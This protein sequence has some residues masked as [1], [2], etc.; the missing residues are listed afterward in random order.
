MKR[1]IEIAV[2]I[3]SVAAYGQD[4]SRGG[5]SIH[6][7]FAADAGGRTSGI[8]TNV[9]NGIG[10][11]RQTAVVLDGGV[12]TITNNITIP[13]NIELV[14][15][16]GSYLS[17]AAGSTVTVNTAYGN[18]LYAADVRASTN[19]YA[20]EFVEN[21]T[22][23]SNKYSAIGSAGLS[24][25]GFVLVGPLTGTTIYASAELIGASN[26]FFGATRGILG[27]I[28]NYSYANDSAVLA[29]MNNV[30]S[31]TYAAVLAGQGNVSR[32]TFSAVG[33]GYGS[34]ASGQGAFVAAGN[35]ASASAPYSFAHGEATTSS[36]TNS[37]SFGRSSMASGVDSFAANRQSTAGGLASAAFGFASVATNS[38]SF[39]A[40]RQVTAGGISSLA[41]GYMAE[42]RGHASIALGYEVIAHAE[43]SFAEGFQTEAYAA[44]S[45]AEGNNTD[46]NG[47]NSHAQNYGTLASGNNSHAGG[48]QS[49]SSGENSFTHGRETV[50]SG[51]QA[52]SAG[53]K[54][55]A[56]GSNSVAM[57]N[58][59]IAN[60]NNAF[61]WSD[62]T[63]TNNS[64][65]NS[66]S[67]TIAATEGFFV[68]GQKIVDSQ[69]NV[70]KVPTNAVQNR[71]YRI[72]IGQDCVSSGILSSVLGGYSNNVGPTLSFIGGGAFNFISGD[73]SYSTIIGGEGN[74]IGTSKAYSQA[75]GY[76]ARST[77][78]SAWVWS[79]F[80][81]GTPF[82]SATNNSFNVRASG[83]YYLT[84]GPISGN[85]SGLTNAPASLLQI[86]SG[87]YTGGSMV[88]RSTNGTQFFWSPN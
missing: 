29:G 78:I 76:Y 68:N 31:N 27:G 45:H 18:T 63:S 56:S 12:W 75:S 16:R 49:A 79:D 48:Y 60:Y 66:N 11:N 34:T 1:L 24:T 15:A 22:A 88:L 70:S 41:A 51:V 67:F 14:Y 30:V 19:V 87:S 7:V 13:S 46:A 84:G 33:S 40:G 53:H 26:A 47:A 62:G 43:G 4:L 2:L 21:G 77:N 71:D 73:A 52:F 65:S 74:Y 35:T 17:V 61:V 10:T 20:V 64:S 82:S 25:N 8:L 23:L 59:S 44:N 50:S 42:A 38:Y 36:G 57:G 9:L 69:G 83:G 3:A 85:A 80:Q 5:R 6:Q 28:A 81:V 86:N 58:L 37:A 54:T 39:A 72:V 32:G 55:T